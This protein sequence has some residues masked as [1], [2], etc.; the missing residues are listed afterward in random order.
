MDEEVDDESNNNNEAV[1][2]YSLH[3][4]VDSVVST[5]P[6]TILARCKKLS[7]QPTE[8][9]TVVNSGATVHMDNDRSVFEYI[10]PVTDDKGEPLYVQQGDGS[11][12]VVQGMGPVTK[13]INNKYPTRYMS[14]LVEELGTPLYSVK[15][16]MEYQ[17]CYFHAQDKWQH[18]PSLQSQCN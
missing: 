8:G 3:T 16:H 14:Y 17:G 5:P 13:V 4:L 11:N 15:Q 10:T 2:S 6:P 12:L 9:Y 18:S 7:T 1:T